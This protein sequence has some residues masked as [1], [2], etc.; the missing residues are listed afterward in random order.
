[1]DL[2]TTLA[3]AGISAGGRSLVL[4]MAHDKKRADGRFPFILTRGIGKAFVDPSVDV[5]EVEAFLDSELD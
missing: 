5:E 2:P 4:H 1:M 3:E